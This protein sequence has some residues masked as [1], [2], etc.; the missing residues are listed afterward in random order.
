M[1]TAKQMLF[2]MAH[3]TLY[4]CGTLFITIFARVIY[5]EIRF[6]H[7]SPPD[8]VRN[9]QDFR[10]WEPSFTD[11]QILTFH[12]S[13]YYAVRGPFARSLPSAHSEYYFDHNGNYVGRNIDLGDFREPAIFTAPDTQRRRISIQEIPGTQP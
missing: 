11:A 13:T 8:D 12:G 3:W 1:P 7:L 5:D 4:V 6:A 9:I 2:S 10:R